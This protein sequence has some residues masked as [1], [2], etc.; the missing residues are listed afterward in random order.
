MLDAIAIYGYLSTH[1][2]TKFVLY[3]RFSTSI[4]V[5]LLVEG[6]LFATLVIQIYLS[7]DC[8]QVP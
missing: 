1:L 7:S 2:I 6:V 8:S 3:T 5:A 4:D